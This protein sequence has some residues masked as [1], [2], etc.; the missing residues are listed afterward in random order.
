MSTDYFRH[1]SVIAQAPNGH[2]NRANQG[3]T[4]DE[5]PLEHRRVHSV[6]GPLTV[7]QPDFVPRDMSPEP[8]SPT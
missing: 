3:G 6:S 5:I 2:R 8:E 7:L 1:G 4:E